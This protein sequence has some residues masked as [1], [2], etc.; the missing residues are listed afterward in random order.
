MKQDWSIPSPLSA[1][2]PSVL[3]HHT[4][5]CVILFKYGI[6]TSNGSIAER[7]RASVLGHGRGPKFNLGEGMI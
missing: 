5:K 3:S 7:S 6:V 2:L 4:V 1:A